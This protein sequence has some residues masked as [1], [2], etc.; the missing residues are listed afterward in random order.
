MADSFSDLPHTSPCMAVLEIGDGPVG[1][2]Y[3]GARDAAVGGDEELVEGFGVVENDRGLDFL[4]GD[5][6]GECCAVLWVVFADDEHGEVGIAGELVPQLLL[7]V[8][9]L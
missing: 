4:S 3:D 6:F 9:H 7:V 8:C 5:D 1:R 2:Y